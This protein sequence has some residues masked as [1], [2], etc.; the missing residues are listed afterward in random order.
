MERSVT[1]ESQ[2]TLSIKAHEKSDVLN[3]ILQHVSS[4]IA[5]GRVL[6][7]KIMRETLERFWYTE[8]TQV[9]VIVMNLWVV[10]TKFSIFLV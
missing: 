4:F 1:N 2:T 5:H 3:L 7:L 10:A 6:S 9:L 8:N